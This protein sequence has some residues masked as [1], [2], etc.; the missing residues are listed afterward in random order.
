MTLRPPAPGRGRFEAKPARFVG[1]MPPLPAESLPALN[2]EETI[3]QILK[4]GYVAG[5]PERIGC[6]CAVH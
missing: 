3:R 2:F 6:K 5:N 4:Q 1:Q